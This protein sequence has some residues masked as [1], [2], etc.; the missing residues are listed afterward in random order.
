M[1]AAYGFAADRDRALVTVEQSA[2]DI[3]QRGLAAAGRAD[4]GKEL[5]GTHAER[6]AIHRN[7]RSFRRIELFDDVIDHQNAG[8]GGGLC[9]RRA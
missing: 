3:E 9:A 6:N 8:V 4:H 7:Q 1:R 2:D 5:A